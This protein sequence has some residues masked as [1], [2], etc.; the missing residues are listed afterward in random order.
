MLVELCHQLDLDIVAEG[1]EHPSQL[2]FLR[3]RGCFVIQGYIFSK[4]VPA[5][6]IVGLLELGLTLPSVPD[7]V[8]LQS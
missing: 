6:E 5:S 2:E 4:P 7:P 3:E 8:R 1:V